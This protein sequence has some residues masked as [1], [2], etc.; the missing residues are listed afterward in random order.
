MG[1]LEGRRDHPRFKPPLPTVAGLY[2]QPM[3]ADNVETTALVLA[4]L[5]R[6][7]RRYSTTST[8]K[9][10]GHGILSVSG[11]MAYPGQYEAPFGITMCELTE[12]SGDVRPDHEP[13]F[14]VPGG[15]SMPIFGP[16]EPDVSLGYESMAGTDSMLGTRVL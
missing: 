5:T 1:S 8:E 16:D 13:R 12:L 11:H 9:S 3:V 2:A 15:P 6:D 14:W 7:V 4:I 10:K